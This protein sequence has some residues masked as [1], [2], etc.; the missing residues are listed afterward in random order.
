MRTALTWLAHSIRVGSGGLL[1]PSVQA[2][3]STIDGGLNN[4]HLCPTVL[5]TG[6]SKIRVP[7]WSGSGETLFQVADVRSRGGKLRGIF[8]EGTNLVPEGSTLVS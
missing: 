6:K 4:E 1:S 8:Y 7:G 3:V 5:E 2:A